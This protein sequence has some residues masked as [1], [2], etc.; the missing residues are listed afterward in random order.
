LKILVPEIESSLPPPSDNVAG[1]GS[2]VKSGEGELGQVSGKNQV[3]A[4]K[5]PDDL[6]P[7]AY[8]LGA[9]SIY[10]GCG[11]QLSNF[12]VNFT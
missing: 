1:E 6:M 9:T 11:T 7:I 5:Q 4:S 12:L 3:C 2:L 10:L 8:G